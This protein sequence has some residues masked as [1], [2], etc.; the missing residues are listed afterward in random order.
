MGTLNKDLWDAKRAK[1]AIS[2]SGFTRKHIAK[3]L[4]IAVSTLT[5][6]LNGRPPN[7][8]TVKLLAQ[9]LGRAED[10]FFTSNNQKRLSG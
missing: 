3:E 4:G 7:I 6:N 2:D 1:K 9:I 10:Y 8:Q 5:K